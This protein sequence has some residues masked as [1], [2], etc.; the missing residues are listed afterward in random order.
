MK[1]GGDKVKMKLNCFFCH[2]TSVHSCKQ[3]FFFLS[4][5]WPNKQVFFFQSLSPVIRP[6]IFK[7][8]EKKR[9]KIQMWSADF[10][11]RPFQSFYPASKHQWLW[12]FSFQICVWMAGVYKDEPVQRELQ[13][14]RH[15]QHGAGAADEERVSMAKCSQWEYNKLYEWEF[16]THICMDLS[17][18]PKFI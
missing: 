1:L 17:D 13:H 8:G 15:R 10:L 4:D 14:G 6:K 7:L 12:W 3:N 2:T 16:P 11:L 9:K 5:L 18:G